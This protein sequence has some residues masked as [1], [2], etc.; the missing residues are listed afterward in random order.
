MFEVRIWYKLLCHFKFKPIFGSLRIFIYS[1]NTS[2]NNI[3]PIAF[4][5]KKDSE[6]KRFIR[7]HNFL[8]PIDCTLQVQT[9]N[10]NFNHSNKIIFTIKTFL[11][12]YF[13]INLINK[14][15]MHNFFSL[16][17]S[18]S[19]EQSF[20]KNTHTHTNFTSMRHVGNEIKFISRSI[21]C[22]SKADLE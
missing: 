22:I 18:S 8:F 2:F 16:S 6:K 12:D 17:M 4:S 21:F 9:R 5:Y 13:F 14:I 11:K 20:Y 15:L 7:C 1:D 3:F 19:Y 10:M